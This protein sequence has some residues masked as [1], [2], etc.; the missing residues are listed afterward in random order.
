MPLKSLRIT[1]VIRI[2]IEQVM[3]APSLVARVRMMRQVIEY[4]NSSGSMAQ[5]AKALVPCSRPR[6]D[7][8]VRLPV[9][10]KQ[11]F[12][13]SVEERCRTIN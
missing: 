6:R 2:G 5:R 10:A 11:K 1:D 4:N 13:L 12:F 9:A 7:S 8:Q 3:C